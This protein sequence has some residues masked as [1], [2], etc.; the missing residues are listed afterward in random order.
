MHMT[1]LDQTLYALLKRVP[2]GKVTTYKALALAA[3]TTAYRAV[4]QAMRKNP[5]APDVPCHRVVSSTGKLGGFMGKTA[6][7]EIQKKIRLLADEGVTVHQGKI[8]DF[9]T[10]LYTFS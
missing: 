5:F 2:R 4:G 9:E 3:G 10:H 7:P 1:T 8:A 6:G